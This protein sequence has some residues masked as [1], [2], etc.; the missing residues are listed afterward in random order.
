MPKTKMITLIFLLFTVSSL[1]FATGGKEQITDIDLN[2]LSGKKL[3]CIESNKMSFSTLS[4]GYLILDH[5]A[6]R[7]S[8]DN[9]NYFVFEFRNTEVSIYNQKS[10][11]EDK[12][13]EKIFSYTE[14]NPEEQ[15]LR[16]DFNDPIPF[17][18]LGSEMVVL[19]FN[20]ENQWKSINFYYDQLGELMI[21][22]YTRYGDY[23]NSIPQHYL[24]TY[25]VIDIK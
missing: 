21:S 23:S 4:N 9:V 16:F 5:Y 11:Q 19:L 7:V 8:T 10:E 12:I 25:R 13:N 22:V 15:T 17:D 3:L 1:V 18:Y 14:I 24:D 2:D 20:S 6:P